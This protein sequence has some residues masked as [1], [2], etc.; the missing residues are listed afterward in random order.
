MR[1]ALAVIAVLA[2]LAVIVL[3]V[4]A[5]DSAADD[6]V[7]PQQLYPDADAIISEASDGRVLIILKDSSSES[8]YTVRTMRAGAPVR[9]ANLSSLEGTFAVVMIGGTVGDLTLVAVDIYDPDRSPVDISFEQVSGTIGRLWAA[10]VNSGI[11]RLVPSDYQ[12][13]YAPFGSI[14][15]TVSGRVT[16]ICTTTGL[17]GTSSV[18]VSIQGGT[19]DRLYP[20]GSDGSHGSLSVR[21]LD[22]TVGYMSNQGAVV[23]SLSY[24]FIRGSI[25]YMCLGADIESRN[26]IDRADKWTFYASGDVDIRIEDGMRI[27]HAILGSGILDRP[28]VLR[29]GQEPVE[30]G[31]YRNVTI[32]CDGTEI[33]ADRAFLVYDRVNAA[34][35][36]GAY[37]F[38]TY[39]IGSNPVS[40]S[41]RQTY[42]Y[43]YRSDYPV[44][45]DDGIWPSADGSLIAPGTIAYIQ[46]AVVVRY[47]TSL[48][49]SHGATAVV[50]GDI[51]VYGSMVN[52][53]YVEIGGLIEER[54]SGDYSGN[55]PDGTGRLAQTIYSSSETVRLDLMTVTR[56]AVAIRGYSGAAS[57]GTAMVIFDMIGCTILVSS[58]DGYMSGDPVV[59]SVEEAVPESGWSYAWS[60]YVSAADTVTGTVPIMLLTVPVAA[61]AGYQLQIA[62]PSGSQAEVRSSDNSGTTFALQGNGTYQLRPYQAVD[63]EPDEPEAEEEDDSFL[64]NIAIAAAIVAIAAIV[65]YLLL[66]RPRGRGPS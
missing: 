31:V 2:A 56:T 64:K 20:S 37:R 43:N 65:V 45:G 6:P 1:R 53:G 27:S 50:T 46:S 66:R 14:S 54:E 59:I 42:S 5:Q 63:P 15:L 49:V 39:T 52:S 11:S 28:A 25:E 4:P 29:N 33:V 26:S 61:D 23:G 62:G 22:G 34:G 51:A 44:Y 48:Q 36:G 3:A 7:A 10:T 24:S 38:Q 57:F 55:A 8:G 12:S 13:P 21:M 30:S 35:T 16:E 9:L 19:V 60:V 32:D 18:S 40:A 47:G 58:A 41:I 17:I